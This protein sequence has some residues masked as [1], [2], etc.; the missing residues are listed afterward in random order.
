MAY[1]AGHA[2]EIVSR[3]ELLES[4]WYGEGLESQTRTIDAHIRR[5][6]TKLPEADLIS[7]LRGQGYRFNSTP[8]VRV[9]N[10]RV[11]TLAA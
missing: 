11:H 4:V 9:S 7:T 8:N 5:L 2:D 6:R 10:T 1:L 3:E